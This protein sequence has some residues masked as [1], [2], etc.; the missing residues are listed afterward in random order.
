M[1]PGEKDNEND[2]EEHERGRHDNEKQISGGVSVDDRN[3][4]LGAV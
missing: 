2:G 3:A 4:T 1:A